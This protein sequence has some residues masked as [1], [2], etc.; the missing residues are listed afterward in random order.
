M[1]AAMRT[2]RAKAVARP[3]VTLLCLEGTVEGMAEDA[4]NVAED[5]AV[6]EEEEDWVDDAAEEEE[7]AEDPLF[8]V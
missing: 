5:N 6:S 8:T 1:A 3:T 2:V 4:D 7:L